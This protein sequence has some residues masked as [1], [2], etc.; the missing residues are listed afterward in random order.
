[1]KKIF[2]ALSLITCIV[3][4]AQI[5]QYGYQSGPLIDTKNSSEYS[6]V[7]GSLYLN[8]DDFTKGKIFVD[9]KVYENVDLRYNVYK[10]FI[11]I[12]MS[13]NEIYKGSTKSNYAYEVYGKKFFLLD[14]QDNNKTK[15][16]YL[17]CLF[18]TEDDMLLNKYIKIY[19]PPE[20]AN[21]GYQKD[22]PAKF[23]DNQNY[24][25]KLKGAD[26]AIPLENNTK[27]ILAQFNNKQLDKFVKEKKLNLK[28]EEDLIS[29]FKY[30]VN[31]NQ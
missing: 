18:C 20:K 25:I 22:K 10:D 9:G 7:D 5:D 15:T 27:R 11:E 26:Y 1:M 28:K 14:Y 6:G 16:G 17:E 24:Y 29:F 3:L 23:S 2:L 13:E 21:T 8:G 4:Q 30:Y 31:I 12:K 19:Y